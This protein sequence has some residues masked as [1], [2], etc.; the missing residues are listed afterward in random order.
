MVNRYCRISPSG[1]ATNPELQKE[2]NAGG[3]PDVKDSRRTDRPE[4]RTN[5]IIWLE[6]ISWFGQVPD[7][8][9]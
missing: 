8:A 4:E 2:V 7:T 9:L 1:V 5:R 6:R 3:K